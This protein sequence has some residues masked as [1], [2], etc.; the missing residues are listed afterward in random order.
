MSPTNVE[1]CSNCGRLLLHSE[2]AY[3]VR[4]KIVCP[5]CDKLLR[6][7]QAP[8]PTPSPKPFP[9]T[10]KGIMKS[11]MRRFTPA[12]YV[13]TLICFFLPFTHISCEGRKVASF[14]GIQLVTGTSITVEG[15]V[16]KIDPEP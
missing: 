7:E 12:I 5:E 8:Q 9:E 16:E 3:V 2:Q 14:T 6:S 15:E 4:G 10:R 13:L 1:I 11:E